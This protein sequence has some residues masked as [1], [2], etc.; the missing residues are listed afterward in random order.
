MRTA[1]TVI[2]IA[3]LCFSCS[4]SLPKSAT[5]DSKVATAASNEVSSALIG[6]QITVRGEL[7]LG[8][9]GWYILLDNQRKSI[10][11]L[12]DRFRGAP[13]MICVASSSWRQVYSAF[14]SVLRIH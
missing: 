1:A 12:G 8:K 4:R 10:S 5:G 7:L 3:F 2:L 9:N 11:F 6:K 14:L 13:M